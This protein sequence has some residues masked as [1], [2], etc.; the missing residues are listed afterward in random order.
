MCACTVD[1]F[2]GP[3]VSYVRE[4]DTYHSLLQRFGEITGDTEKDWERCRLAVVRNRTP[5]F[6]TRPQV[7]KVNG[8]ADSQH[9]SETTTVASNTTAPSKTVWSLLL[10]HNLEFMHHASEIKYVLQYGPK[11]YPNIGIQRSVADLALTNKNR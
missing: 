2:T 8:G 3:F 5:Y 10:E 7:H 11:G 6:L 9:G 4:D 1:D